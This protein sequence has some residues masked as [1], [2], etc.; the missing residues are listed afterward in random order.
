M[1]SKRTTV[2]SGRDRLEE[3]YSWVQDGEQHKKL[4]YWQRLKQEAQSEARWVSWD[5][6]RERKPELEPSIDPFA[7]R[8]ITDTRTNRPRAHN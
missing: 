6:Q 2:R 5:S 1:S 8:Y 7:K 4:H 3:E